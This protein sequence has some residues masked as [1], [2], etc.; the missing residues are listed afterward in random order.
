MSHPIPGQEYPCE[1][2][3]QHPDDCE[4]AH[5]SKVS[6]IIHQALQDADLV[7][8]DDI[9]EHNFGFDEMFG[10]IGGQDSPTI[11]IGLKKVV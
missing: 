2:C 3:G 1:H 5:L 9:P 7:V 4:C 6:R 11:V 10:A 8:H